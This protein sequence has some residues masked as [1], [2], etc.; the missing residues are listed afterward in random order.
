M[1]RLNFLEHTY[2]ILI[3]RALEICRIYGKRRSES[4]SSNA[5]YGILPKNKS[6]IGPYPMNKVQRNVNQSQ[7]FASRLQVFAVSA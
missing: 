2:S 3:K 5:A 1:G 7:C 6:F 4:V